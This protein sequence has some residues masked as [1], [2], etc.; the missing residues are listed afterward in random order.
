ME[1]RLA[2]ARFLHAQETIIYILRKRNI[3]QHS[4]DFVHFL[5]EMIVSSSV[6]QIVNPKKGL[7]YRNI[8]KWLCQIYTV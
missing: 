8:K 1:A 6:V 4:N 3:L 7:Y 2:M 5:I